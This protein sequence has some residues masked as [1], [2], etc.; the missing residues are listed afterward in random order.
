[1]RLRGQPHST[2]VGPAD[3]LRD[4]VDPPAHAATQGFPSL[5][6]LENRLQAVN[7]GKGG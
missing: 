6:A 1:M 2:V 4:S 7:L 5:R 3:G